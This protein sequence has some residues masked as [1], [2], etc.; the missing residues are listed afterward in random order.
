MSKD[1]ETVTR[2]SPLFSQSSQGNLA[3]TITEQLLLQAGLTIVA[4]V[5]FTHISSFDILLLCNRNMY[6][7][8]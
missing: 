6:G 2:S 7:D 5:I 8:Y 1:E 3:F 4:L